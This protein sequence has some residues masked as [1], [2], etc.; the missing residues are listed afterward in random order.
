MILLAVIAPPREPLFGE[1]PDWL[2]PAILI[3]IVVCN[4]VLYFFS[5]TM[6]RHADKVY[7][8]GFAAYKDAKAARDEAIKYYGDTSAFL[9]VWEAGPACA[10]CGHTRDW[11]TAQFLPEIGGSEI[12]VRVEHLPDNTVRASVI[13]CTWA[14]DLVGKSADGPDTYK[15]HDALRALLVAAVAT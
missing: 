14:P 11:S 12:R 10:W 1:P 9:K 6:R 3:A 8:A 15:A 13:E 4:V 5:V 2:L 7:K